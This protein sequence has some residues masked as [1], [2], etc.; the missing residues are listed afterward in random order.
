[1]TSY[2]AIFANFKY[3]MQWEAGI[4]ELWETKKSERILDFGNR[5]KMVKFV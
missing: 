5:F 1:M 3:C 2:M 4:P